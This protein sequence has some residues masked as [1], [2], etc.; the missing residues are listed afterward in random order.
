[1]KKF[2]QNSIVPVL[3]SVAVVPF[4]ASAIS[5]GCATAYDGLAAIFCEI[6][7]LLSMVV[8]ILVALG[9]VYFV[10]GVVRYV[11]G[12]SEEAK[13]KGRDQ[14]IFGI[15]GFVVIIGLW[16]I[17]YLVNNT[18]DTGGYSAPSSVEFQGLLPQ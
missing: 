15:I 8:P 1:M 17:V 3:V 14:M 6:G 7:D 2:L 4:M 13:K 11:I 16:G 5:F 18:F 12:D 10:W 9:V